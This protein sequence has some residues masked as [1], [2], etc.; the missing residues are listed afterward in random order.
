MMIKRKKA[1]QNVVEYSEFYLPLFNNKLIF[2]NHVT[3]I[4]L[5]FIEKKFL[6]DK[7][8]C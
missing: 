7:N 5:K 3:I 2:N 6:I 4:L 8:K 1:N